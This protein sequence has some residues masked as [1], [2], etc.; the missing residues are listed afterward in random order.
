MSAGRS[1]TRP[2]RVRDPAELRPVRWKESS[3]DAGS[4][5]KEL[6]TSK[7]SELTGEVDGD[8]DGMVLNNPVIDYIRS[9]VPVHEFA[10]CTCLGLGRFQAKVT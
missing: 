2:A 9:L 8:G 5:E 6:R 7:Q 10:S 1:A 4:G 3:A